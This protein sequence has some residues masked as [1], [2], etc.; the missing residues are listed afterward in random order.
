MCG[1]GRSTRFSRPAA[2]R[3][4]PGLAF[5][6]STASSPT[7]SAAGLTWI[8]SPD[9]AH[10]FTWFCRAWRPWS[11]LR[12]RIGRLKLPRLVGVDQLAQRGLEDLA[13]FA[14]QRR[15]AHVGGR[16]GKCTGDTDADRVGAAE[17][18][19][20]VGAGRV[21]LHQNLASEG[22]FLHGVAADIEQECVA[23]EDLAVPK[24]DDAAALAGAAVL[25]DDMDRI[26]PI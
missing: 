4:A 22:I 12:S 15:A 8:P 6:S 24:Q 10:A 13:G 14:D 11:R 20:H 9:T 23:A 17:Q 16:I 1:G 7:A 19:G 21:A 18:G 2:I 3:A 5:T 26:K 25:E